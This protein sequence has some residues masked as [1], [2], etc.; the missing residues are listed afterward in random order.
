MT[1]PQQPETEQKGMSRRNFMKNTGLVAGGLV[2]GSLLGGLVTNQVKK[3]TTGNEASTENLLEARTFFS[4]SEDFEI[5][6]AATERIFPKDDL[7]PGAI[8][9]GVPYFIDRQ[10]SG[11]WGTNAKEYMRG[12]FPQNAEKAN[13]EDKDRQQDEQGPNAETQVPAP[14]PRYQTPMTRAEI[15]TEGLRALE[16][17]AQE[18]FETNFRKLEASQQDEILQLFNEGK[19]KMNGVS[20]ETFFNLLL[21]TTIEGT[22]ADPV[23]GGNRNME[24]WRMKEFPGPRMGYTDGID[25]KDFIVMK[26]E[27]LRSYQGH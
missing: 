14:T 8:E 24:A 16:Q 1:G 10:L 12:P 22:Y 3:P 4:R 20:S 9:L 11:E 18:K 5:L 17:T 2:G 7:G 27:S 21:Q 26:P 19:G 15:F 25:K 23:Y 13:Y 6:S